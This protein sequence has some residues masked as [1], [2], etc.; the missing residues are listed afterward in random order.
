MKKRKYLL[1]AVVILIVTGLFCIIYGQNKKVVLEVGIFSDSNWGVPSANAYVAMD[2]AIEKFEEEHPGVEVHY[3]SGIRKKDYYEWLS[4]KA[5]RGELP[6]VFF[7]TSEDFYTYSTMGILKE[8]DTRVVIDENFR[9]EYFFKTGIEAGK[10]HDIQ[11][12]LPYEMVPKLMFVNRTLLEKEGF[13]VPDTDWT[14]DDMEEICRAVTK[15]TDGDGVIDQFGT[16]NYGWKEAAYSN[17]AKM[18]DVD[19]KKAYFSDKKMIDAVKFTKTLNNLNQKRKVTQKD[20]EA[21]RVAFMPLSFA[22]YRMYKTYPY[23]IKKYS[24]FRWDCTTMPAGPRGDNISEVNTLLVGMNEHTRYEELSWEFMKLLTYD[25][26]VQRNI[27]KYSQGASGLKYITGSKFAESIIRRDMD[28]NEKVID[29]KLLESV[30]E[31]GK[32]VREFSG[33]DSAMLFAESGIEEI[34]ENGKNVESSIKILQ[35]DIVNFIK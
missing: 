24:G 35:R 25:T 12:A 9:E 19:G 18:F 31:N 22:E 6:D 1:W 11:Y 28:A 17:D 21:G 32:T 4:R 34:Y 2:R 20:F 13:S 5:M 33:Y 8:L 30:I 14:W 3:E 15:D 7:V 26:E 16:Y 29:C 10:Y 23:K 27:F